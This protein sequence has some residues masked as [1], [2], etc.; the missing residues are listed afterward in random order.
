MEPA[1]LPG[2]AGAARAAGTALSGMSVSGG[3]VGAARR[4][5][6]QR[7]M[8][9]P[10]ARRRS[11]TPAT[12]QT[13]HVAAEAREIHARAGG[14]Q[15][16]VGDRRQQRG[17]RRHAERAPSRRAARI[18]V[19]KAARPAMFM[20]TKNIT[21]M[22]GMNQSTGAWVR[23]RAN[24]SRCTASTSRRPVRPAFVHSLDFPL[25]KRPPVRT[26][27]PPHEPP[28]A[29]SRV[30][31]PRMPEGA[32]GLRTHHHAAARRGLPGRARLRDRGRGRREHLRLHRLRRGRI[33]GRDRRGA[34]AQRQGDRHRLPGCA[35]RTHPRTPSEGAQGHRPA[36]L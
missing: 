16:D 3:S 6:I 15:Q 12:R 18:A 24:H 33:A 25:E 26:I 27:A 21:M 34:G 32:G 23:I 19:T 35:A 4:L 22:A 1:S 8:P 10:T 28:P 5:R 36:R 11:R 2:A 31:Q 14:S 30:R 20:V 9:P 7:P 29:K 17:E 13:G